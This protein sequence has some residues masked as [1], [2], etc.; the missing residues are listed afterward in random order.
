MRPHRTDSIQSLA[1]AS[2]CIRALLNSMV[3]NCATP[4]RHA[5]TWLK[6]QGGACPVRLDVM[7]DKNSPGAGCPTLLARQDH[8]P[9]PGDG[10]ARSATTGPYS[11]RRASV[12]R[13]LPRA[14][15]G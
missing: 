5:W 8:T 9:L 7:A 10:A 6:R 11:H 12:E 14:A 1:L 2:V 3:G 13:W 4:R 15:L